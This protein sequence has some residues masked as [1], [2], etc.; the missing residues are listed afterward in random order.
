MVIDHGS[1]FQN[2]MMTELSTMLGFR[3]EH[4]SPYYPQANGQVEA[5]NKTLK[6][7]LQR[8]VN[9]SRNNWHIMLYPA[10]WEYHTSIKIATGFSPFQL[11]QGVEAILPIECEIPSLKLDVKL[12]PETSILEERL[13]YLEH[14]DENRRD[15]TTENE[16]HKKRVKSQYDK[17]VKPRVFSEGDLVLLYDQDKEP[18]GPGKF[19]SMWIGP[20]IVSKVLKKG[21]YELTDYEGNKLVEPRNGLYLKKYYA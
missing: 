18:L 19:N 14:L 10:L 3:Q 17:S 8:T 20:Y 7:I 5:V 16:A 9:I 4:S 12:L 11:V 2:K 21:A 1:H 13:I 6:T 15:A